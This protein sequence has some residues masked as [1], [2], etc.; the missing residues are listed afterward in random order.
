MRDPR[1][2][3]S[4]GGQMNWPRDSGPHA[5]RRP[6]GRP[7]AGGPVGGMQ[8]DGNSLGSLA[9]AESP[10]DEHRAWR[11]R[12]GR[13]PCT[14]GARL[15]RGRD[16]LG[17]LP[18]GGPRARPPLPPPGGHPAATPAPVD[19]EDGTGAVAP[20]APRGP[21]HRQRRHQALPAPHHRARVGRPRRDPPAAV[22]LAPRTTEGAAFCLPADHATKPF[23]FFLFL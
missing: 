18:G 19:G 2:S 6:L 20:P 16:G 4:R 3:E 10:H 15:T 14:R 13:A 22:R 1:R 17:R 23:F 8:S 11:R 12:E 7:P 21:S 5:G 9:G